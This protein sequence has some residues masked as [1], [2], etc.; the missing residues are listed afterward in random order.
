MKKNPPPAP[1]VT[2]SP[3]VRCAFTRLVPVS[4]LFG[5]R[6]PR[7]PN[8]HPPAQ[9]RLLA[10]IMDATGIRNPIVVSNRSGLM[11]KGHGRL[12][13][14]VLNAYDAFPVDFQDYDSPE[15][16]IA[17]VLADNLIQDLSVMKEKGMNEL[18]R[19]LAA[20]GHDTE[21]AGLLKK[22]EDAGE[23]RKK[24]AGKLKDKFV[25]S[26]FTVLDTRNKDW[27]AR[28]Q[29]WL[30]I[31]MTGS[32][33]SPPT[34][35][36]A[37]QPKHVSE[38][39][40]KYEKAIGGSVSW[41]A[42]LD[43]HPNFAG[44]SPI[45]DISNPVI[46]E[47]LYNWF[48]PTRRPG[49]IL[50]PF[51][52]DSVRGIVAAMLGHSYT[53]IDLSAA[54]VT[55]NTNSAR[56]IFDSLAITPKAFPRWIVGDSAKLDTIL[57]RSEM[58]DFIF[59]DIPTPTALSTE[60]PD[61]LAGMTGKKYET[62]LARIIAGASARLFSNRFAAWIAQDYRERETGSLCSLYAATIDAS[63]VPLYNH[64]AILTAVQTLAIR[65]GKEFNASRQLGKAHKDAAILFNGSRLDLEAAADAALE[66]LAIFS[67]GEAAR[68][69][70]SLGPLSAR[71]VVPLGDI[72]ETLTAPKQ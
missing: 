48:L 3:V 44:R 34:N 56:E 55:A 37:P 2:K 36:N 61:D 65:V 29:L 1:P 66:H 59:A 62:T 72:L 9:V 52:G 4:E 46:A 39:K 10:K 8:D 24:A 31:G 63:P 33:G 17:D 57:D 38:A 16:E 18:L 68:I 12:E 71:E 47:A 53:G 69:P 58:F 22:A 50:D 41:D 20:A 21:L 45:P 13:A 11:T 49:R 25:V 60:S 35:S 19:E 32:I 70:E 30:Q 64:A 54:Q 15:Q 23:K 42:F 7:N 5:L 40:A 43:S 28:R 27:L 26:P 67:N 14:A 6:N 51:A